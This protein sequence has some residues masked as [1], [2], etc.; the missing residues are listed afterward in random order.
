MR[1]YLDLEDLDFC[2][3]V[4]NHEDEISLFLIHKESQHTENS[5]TWITF[6]RLNKLLRYQLEI[7]EIK[8]VAL[9]TGHFFFL[10]IIFG[11]FWR[12][13]FICSISFTLLFSLLFKI[14]KMS[15]KVTIQ[16]KTR[17][18]VKVLKKNGHEIWFKFFLN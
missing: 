6:T 17:E 9:T 3:I 2:L 15:V 16:L 11:V 12:G 5:F 4:Y 8:H 18:Q 13:F 1:Q 14:I 10:I 7:I